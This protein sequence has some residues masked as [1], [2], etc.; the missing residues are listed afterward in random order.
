[1]FFGIEEA[2]DGYRIARAERQAATGT[3]GTPAPPAVMVTG[4]CD[5]VTA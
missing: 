4:A 2:V 5:G 3:T 1:M